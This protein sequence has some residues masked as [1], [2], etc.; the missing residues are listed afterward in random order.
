MMKQLKSELPAGLEKIVFRCLV[1]SIVFLLFWV[2]VLFFADQLMVSVH[3][4]FFGISDSDLGK[5]EYD[6][7]LINYQLMG[8]FKLS[9]TTFFLIPWLVLRF[10]RDC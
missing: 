5:F 10:S 8:V 1:I 3:A 2:A 9:A 4:K 7:K 6:A